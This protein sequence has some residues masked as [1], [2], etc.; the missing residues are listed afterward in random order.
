MSKAAGEYL[1]AANC[2]DHQIVR[3]AAIYGE[4]PCLAKDGRNFV[5]L[6]LHLAETRGEVKVV[7]DEFTTPTYTKALAAQLRLL[8]EKG[9]PG[10]Y[11]ATC[12]GA[13]SWYEFAAAIFEMTGTKVALHQATS[14]DF[15]SPVQRPSYS[16]LEN[17]HLQAQGIDIIPPWREALE[18]YLR[19]IGRMT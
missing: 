13:C 11:H 1:I 7:T 5:G 6:M 12:Q 18:E 16:V 14:A 17:A 10:L 8:V 15:P 19:A 2:R 3:T 9:K 4:A